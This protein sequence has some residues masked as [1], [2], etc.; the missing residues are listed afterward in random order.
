MVMHAQWDS[1]SVQ[2]LEESKKVL[3]GLF[4][5]CTVAIVLQAQVVD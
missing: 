3:T 1:F 5:V 2:S 4:Y